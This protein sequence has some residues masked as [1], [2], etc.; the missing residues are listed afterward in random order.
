M[1]QHY[2]AMVISE[3]PHLFCLNC[4]QVSTTIW[5]P[6][7]LT[8][9]GTSWV[10]FNVPPNTLI[11]HIE[12]EFLCVRWPN[13]HCQSTDLLPV[14]QVLYKIATITYRALWQQQPMYISSLLV[15]YRLQ[16][17]SA[18]LFRPSTTA[19]YTLSPNSCRVGARCFSSATPGPVIWSSL[20]TDV[21]SAATNG[22]FCTRLKTVPCYCI[23]CVI[24]ML[25]R[26]W[27]TCWTCETRWTLQYIPTT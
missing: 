26:Y 11:G 22:I 16:H 13:Q 24:D 21:N 15:T 12:D 17:I 20:P 4:R 2:K 18:T 1:F 7:C 19:Q 8:L 14:R 23:N 3:Q 9:A 25:E 5:K 6:M 27:F 10:R